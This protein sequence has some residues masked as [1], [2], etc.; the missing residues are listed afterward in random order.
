MP[1][2]FAAFRRL[3]HSQIIGVID[4]TAI[5]MKIGSRSFCTTSNWPRP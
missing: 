5:R 1:A 3:Y 2:A 4:A